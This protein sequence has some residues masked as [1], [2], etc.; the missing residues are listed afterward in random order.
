MTKERKNYRKTM[1]NWIS[2]SQY[3]PITEAI[4]DSNI[5]PTS[6]TGAWISMEPMILKTM[7]YVVNTNIATMQW[8]KEYSQ[9]MFKRPRLKRC[10]AQEEMNINS[11]QKFSFFFVS[12]VGCKWNCLYY[13]AIEVTVVLFQAIAFALENLKCMVF[14]SL[15]LGIW[16]I[17]YYRLMF[18]SMYV[19]HLPL[20]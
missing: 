15:S 11:L 8:Q 1:R 5:F 16:K 17:Q 13:Y 3:K 10:L 20:A 12:H 18:I 4:L 19:S 2:I 7:P 6:I 14:N 9:I